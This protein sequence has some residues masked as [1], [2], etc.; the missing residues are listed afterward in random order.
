MSPPSSVILHVRCKTYSAIRK[1]KIRIGSD[2]GLWEKHAEKK[3]GR[4]I[5]TEIKTEFLVK[6]LLI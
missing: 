3:K 5:R 1:E 2:L 6:A 4:R